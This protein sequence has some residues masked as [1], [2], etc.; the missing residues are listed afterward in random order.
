LRDLWAERRAF[1]A[2]A[3]LHIMSAQDDPT[4]TVDEIVEALAQF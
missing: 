1:Y 2:E 3:N 4:L